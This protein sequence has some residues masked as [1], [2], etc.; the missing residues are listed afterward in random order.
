MKY[1]LCD[2]H[3]IGDCILIL[4]VAKAIKKADPNAEIVVFTSSNKKKIGINR[5]IMKLQNYVDRFEYYSSKEILHTIYFT[6]R[7]S[8]KR[9][10][11]GI[12]VQDYDNQG[13]SSIPSY[14]VRLCAKKT[15]GTKILSNKN[16][17]YDIFIERE[18]GVCRD[19]YF[20]R[21]LRIFGIEVD[22]VDTDLLDTNKVKANIPDIN[23]DEAKQTVAL[24]L[25]TAPVSLKTDEGVK[26]NDTKRWPYENWI[27]LADKLSGQFNVLLLGGPREANEIKQLFNNILDK[28]IYNLAGSY[29]IEQSISLLSLADVVVGADTG[30]MHCAGALGK[31]SIT[32][33]G[34]TDHNE[35][36][37]FGKNSFYIQSD[38]DCS[39]CF[40]TVQSV[41]CEHKKC[42]SLISVTE[43]YNRILKVF[44][45]IMDKETER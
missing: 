16:I 41:L 45:S 32:L 11:Y 23:I 40:G 26:T 15:C 7:N 8:I 13:V 38:V 1:L 31:P 29:K 19:E 44:E 35:Y 3:G 17:K 27:K 18:K 14:I 2:A 12:V 39:P 34:C 25:G 33:F 20:R 22:K 6:I 10:D 43:V 21:A 28:T 30:L 36:L 9:F 4:P 37:P 42:M 5:G 24:V